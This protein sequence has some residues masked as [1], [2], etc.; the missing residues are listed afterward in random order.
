L[1]VLGHCDRGTLSHTGTQT[2]ERPT[3]TQTTTTTTTTAAAA[4]TD[5]D[6]GDHDKCKL[7]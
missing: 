4:T 6:D 1:S 7:L 5:D 3:H 2:T